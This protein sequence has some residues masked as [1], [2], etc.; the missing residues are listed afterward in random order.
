MANSG[1]VRRF[2]V[3]KCNDLFSVE[4]WSTTAV[5]ALDHGVL[6]EH[7]GPFRKMRSMRGGGLGGAFV[8]VAAAELSWSCHAEVA[9]VTRCRASKL[10]F[11]MH[12]VAPY[13]YCDEAPVAMAL[14]TFAVAR[15]FVIA[16]ERSCP[17]VYPQREDG[18]ALGKCQK[19]M[20]SVVS[21]RA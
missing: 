10:K 19:V 20:G 1:G 18:G 12:A 21:Q 4:S 3:T 11:S 13:V 8:R 6:G 9:V 5:E 16:T 14:F 15:A 2:D 7:V 17:A